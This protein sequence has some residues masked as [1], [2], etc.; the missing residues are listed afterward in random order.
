[1]HLSH[2]H[3]C[4]LNVAPKCGLQA[5]ELL[6]N[7]VQEQRDELSNL[8][9]AATHVTV[10]AHALSSLA[11]EV[12]NDAIAAIC[13]QVLFCSVRFTLSHVLECLCML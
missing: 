12:F 8:G 4:P 9:E 6:K 10:D 1:M 7:L 13:Q 11:S 2:A 5:Q 3:Y